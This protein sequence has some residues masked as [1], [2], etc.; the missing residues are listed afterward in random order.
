M[1]FQIFSGLVFSQAQPTAWRTE[2]I[3]FVLSGY[4]A[5]NTSGGLTSNS[6]GYYVAIYA[7]Q[8]ASGASRRFIY[9]SAFPGYTPETA[10]A[11]L[12]VA[13]T[14]QSTG[15]NITISATCVD[16]CSQNATGGI[17]Y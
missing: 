1:I 17:V 8:D 15:S 16:N 13:L 4:G 5:S 6:T 10:R 11:L 14:A 2:K 12:S 3:K 7:P 9:N